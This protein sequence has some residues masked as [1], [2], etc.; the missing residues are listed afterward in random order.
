MKLLKFKRRK[1]VEM[2]EEERRLHELYLQELMK[3]NKK[4]VKIVGAV[5]WCLGMVAWAILL[6]LDVMHHVGQ[7]KILFHG[8]AAALTALVALPT[9]LDYFAVRKRK[10]KR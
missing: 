9:I 2:T 10:P 1:P 7:V 4:S 5:L 8:V 6:T 3:K